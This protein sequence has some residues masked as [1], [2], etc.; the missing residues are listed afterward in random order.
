MRR[1]EFIAGAGSACV[2][3][4]A[5]SAQEGAIPKIGVLALGHPDPAPLLK[6][7]REGLQALGYEEGKNIQLEFRSAKGRPDKL[8]ALAAEL[9]ALRV[10]AIVA[11]QTPA[12]TAAKQVTRDIP[13][14]MDTVGDPVGTGLVA[15]L[16]HPGGNITGVTGAT[17]EL[18]AKNLEL[19][20][21]VLPSARRAAI[22]AN[23]PDPFS[24]PFLEHIQNAATTL[25]FEILPIKV[26]RGVDE[27]EEDFAAIAN[28]QAQ[29]V[30]VQPSLPEK[31][32][33]E[34]ALKYKV[35]A[36]APT[37]GFPALGGLMSYSADLDV[38][39][40]KGARFIDDILKGRSPADLPVEL[41]TKFL[42][43]VNLKTAQA[44]GVSV[45]G[46]M[47]TRADEVIE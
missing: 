45:P 22:L 28:W 2:W 6:S 7:L 43:I 16:A 19:V 41:A 36:F 29:A 15:S 18:G 23:A 4:A 13:I 8:S 34:L 17:S 12:A 42:L 10:A 11:F 1:R 30:V 37:A 20:R 9:V 5:S 3:V 38:L 39:Y 33:A 14:V 46:T 44:L 21:E 32:I 31:Q 24:K 25:K 27:L 47:L 40:R 35:P 26:A